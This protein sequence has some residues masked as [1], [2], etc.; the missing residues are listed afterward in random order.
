MIIDMTADC[1]FMSNCLNDLQK[2]KLLFS[3]IIDQS[4]SRMNKYKKL[5]S[6]KCRLTYF[7]IFIGCT[8]I[9]SNMLY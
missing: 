7:Y 2:L 9:K 4:L 1:I 6:G 5:T 3:C 8:C